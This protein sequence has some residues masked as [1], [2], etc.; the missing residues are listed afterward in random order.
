MTISSAPSP[1]PPHLRTAAPS[2][3]RHEFGAGWSVVLVA[4]VGIAAGLSSTFFYSTGL[5][6]K[7]IAE[8]FGWG[9]GDVGLGPLL[10]TV[11]TA[12][13]APLVG[14]LVDRYGTWNVVL[15]SMA[16]LSAGLFLIAFATQGFTSYLL[17]MGLLALLGAGTTPLPFTRAVVGAFRAHRGLALG[18]AISGSGVGA[19]LVPMFLTPYILE[20]GWRGGYMILAAVVAAGLVIVLTLVLVARLSVGPSAAAPLAH[21]PADLSSGGET[22]LL[23][24]RAFLVLSAI[25]FLA[26]SAIMTVII[27]FVPMLTDAGMT[28]ARAG[29]LAGTIGAAVIVGRIVAGFLLDRVRAEAL[30]AVLFLSVAVAMLLLLIGGADLA[31]AAAIAAGLGVGAEI[32]LMAYLAAR[33]FPLRRYGAAYGA[34]YAIFLVGAS[35]GPTVT[36]YLFDFTGDYRL[37]LILC[38]ASLGGATMLLTAIPKPRLA[39]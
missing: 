17:L 2:A 6:M 37:A 27:H 12:L 10:T 21:Q 3:A 34:L 5:F 26:A 7:P 23:R 38:A 16:G 32:D 19:A 9:R 22:P 20:L 25:F 39:I 36:G 31:L 24:D 8:E 1:T 11:L 28:P 13:L 30:A 29:A 33:H 18:L 15:P 35:L 4:F 14:R